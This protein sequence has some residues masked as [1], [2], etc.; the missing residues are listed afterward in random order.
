MSL[1]TLTLGKSKLTKGL[2]TNNEKI[3]FSQGYS[4][5]KGNV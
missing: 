5:F 1:F 4:H 2:M 3:H